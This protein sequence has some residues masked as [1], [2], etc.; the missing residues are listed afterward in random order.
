MTLRKILHYP[1]PR[2]RLIA[3]LVDEIDDE[4]RQLVKDMFETM[5]EDNGGGLAATQIDA[6]KRI[7]VI[8]PGADKKIQYVLINP[9][10]IEE[11]GSMTGSEGCLSVPG[12]SESVTRAE[13]VKVKAL[14]LNGKEFIIEA[15][16]DYLAA[17]LQHEIDHLNGK[18]FIDGLSSMKVQRIRKKIEKM[19]KTVM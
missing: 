5:Y 8:D 18:L 2:L 10:I 1:N 13:Y 3:E 15:K 17:C 7:V 6:H 16:G 19:K 4:I 12:V 9:E 11:E 14:D